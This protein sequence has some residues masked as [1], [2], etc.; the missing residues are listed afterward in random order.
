MSS[1]GFGLLIA[2]VLLAQSGIAVGH[3]GILGIPTCI[4]GGENG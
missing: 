4:P 1:M 3:R 2:N